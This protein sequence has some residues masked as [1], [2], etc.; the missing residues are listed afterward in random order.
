MVQWPKEALAWRRRRERL[1]ATTG[2]WSS[3]Q[4]AMWLLEVRFILDVTESL[5]HWTCSLSW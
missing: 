1:E 5:P 3:R 4:G 2:I